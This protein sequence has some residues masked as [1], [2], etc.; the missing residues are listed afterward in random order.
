M[1]YFATLFDY[2]YLSRGI[3]LYNSLKLN[4]KD[5]TIYILA[6]DIQT[7][8]FF[9]ENHFEHVIV[10]SLQELE[11]NDSRL[12]SIKSK[13]S[14][15]EYYFTISPCLPL[16]LLNK[17]NLPHI[18]TLDADIKFYSNPSLLFDYLNEYSMVITPHKFSKENSTLI[19][20]GEF[21]V[22]F[23]IF[24]NDQF[25]QSCLNSWR[26]QCI[27]WCFDYIDGSKFADQGYLN[28]WPLI[29]N[30]SLKILDDEVS[31]IA[32]WNVNQF[33]LEYKKKTI[34]SNSKELIFYHF[35]GFNSFENRIATSS[36]E[37]YNVNISH[38][39]KKL[40]IDYWTELKLINQQFHLNSIFSNRNTFNKKVKDLVLNQIPFFYNFYNLYFSFDSRKIPGKIIFIFNKI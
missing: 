21:N 22:S 14:L 31:G 25:G 12:F 23:Q 11:E 32:P 19:S 13:R 15:F 35:Q 34:L 29:Y 37:K 33:K 28:N 20:Y 26:N 27:D 1:N 7:E 39:L 24:K 38:S 16:F 8:R 36:F 17:Y 9:I 18:C 30:G 40:Y 6:L 3:V 4:C 2:N 10:I 5:F